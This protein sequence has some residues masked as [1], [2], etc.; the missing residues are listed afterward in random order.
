LLIEIPDP[1]EYGAL[2]A[3][4]DFQATAA[5]RHFEC[6]VGRPSHGDSIILPIGFDISEQLIE[7][8]SFAAAAEPILGKAVNDAFHVE[9]EELLYCVADT[10]AQRFC[11]LELFDKSGVCRTCLGEFPF[12]ATNT[13]AKGLSHCT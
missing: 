11:A 8:P 4:A 7:F 9:K 10:L 12:K 6:S 3:A 2:Q 5:R 13:V 1:S